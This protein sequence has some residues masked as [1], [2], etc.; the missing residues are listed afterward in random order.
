MISTMVP[1]AELQDTG[2]GLVAASTGWFVRGRDRGSV[3]R[4]ER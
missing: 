2:A 1:E 4:P 3:Q